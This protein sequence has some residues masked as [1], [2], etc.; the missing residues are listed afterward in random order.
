MHFLSQSGALVVPN[1]TTFQLQAFASIAQTKTGSRGKF[2]RIL[3]E[4]HAWM[5]P[6]FS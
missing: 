4:N 1:E 6:A 3:R 2:S 5:I